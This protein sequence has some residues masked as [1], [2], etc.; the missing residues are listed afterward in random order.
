MQVKEFSVHG[1]DHVSKL[2]ENVGNYAPNYAEN[3][4]M[5]EQTGLEKIVG[6]YDMFCLEDE[7][8]EEATNDFSYF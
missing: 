6:S 2:K 5:N 7:F 3:D 8:N 1:I 4:L